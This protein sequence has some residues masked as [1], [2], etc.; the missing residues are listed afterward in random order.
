MKI[1]KV[2]CPASTFNT[3]M[4]IATGVPGGGHVGIMGNSLPIGTVEMKTD[5][6]NAIYV[7]GGEERK[8]YLKEG[9][10]LY[11]K[12]TTSNSFSIYSVI[13]YNDE[14]SN[15]AQPLN[16]SGSITLSQN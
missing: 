12:T 2:I 4:V 13:Y 15:Q 3:P 5:S 14:P 6:N 1:Q 10:E 9:E 16:L 7:S 8:F 11:G